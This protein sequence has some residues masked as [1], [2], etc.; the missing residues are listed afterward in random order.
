[1]DPLFDYEMG[2][3]DAPMRL[4]G[5]VHKP[6]PPA[7]TPQQGMHLGQVGDFFS[8]GDMLDP[9]ITAND[10]SVSPPPVGTLVAGSTAFVALLLIAYKRMYHT[11]RRHPHAEES[12]LST[13]SSSP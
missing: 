10:S 2:M 4:R 12:L 11:G 13:T 9:T 6:K 7:S 1:M 3:L 8:T 5:Q